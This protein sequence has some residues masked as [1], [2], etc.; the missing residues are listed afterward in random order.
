MY[1]ETELSFSKAYT[2]L[3]AFTLEKK[4]R[5]IYSLTFRGGIIFIDY[6]QCLYL[7]ILHTWFNQ[8]NN[9]LQIWRK[10]YIRISSHLKSGKV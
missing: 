6:H 9:I 4:G 10:R 5:F 1:Q 8:I 7:G 2:F 3:S